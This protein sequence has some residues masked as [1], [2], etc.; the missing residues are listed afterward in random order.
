VDAIRTVSR[1][2]LALHETAAR[3]LVESQDKGS[4]FARGAIGI[5]SESLTE[6]EQEVLRLLC[7]GCSNK[8][9]EQKLYIS[10]RTVEGRLNSIYGKLGAHSR[11]EVIVAA[12]RVG[13]VGRSP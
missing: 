8:Q 6:R 12:V 9:M 10:V 2:E 4:L 7:E 5:A 1:G 13:W 11:A 3:V